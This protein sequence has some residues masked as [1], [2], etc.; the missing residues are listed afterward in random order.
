MAVTLSAT[1]HSNT[2][3]QHHIGCLLPCTLLLTNNMLYRYLGSTYTSTHSELLF[4]LE[5]RVLCHLACLF[6]LLW[7]NVWKH[8]THEFS[9]KMAVTSTCLFPHVNSKKQSK[10][11]RVSCP[12]QITCTFCI[13][14]IHLYHKL[15]MATLVKF[16]EQAHQSH[17]SACCLHHWWWCVS[18]S[19]AQCVTSF[20]CTLIVLL[21][22]TKLQLSC[23]DCYYHYLHAS[24]RV[25]VCIQVW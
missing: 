20:L 16:R 9:N 4:H 12:Q 2:W 13:E 8:I 3:K 5:I 15:R 22:Y 7:W 18:L 10:T 24:M 6:T 23:K 11:A 17:G 21:E 19:H 25:A 14:W 1:I